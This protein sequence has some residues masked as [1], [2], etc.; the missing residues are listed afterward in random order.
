MNISDIIVDAPSWKWALAILITLGLTLIRYAAL[1]KWALGILRLSVLGTLCFLLLEPLLRISSTEVEPSTVVIV[2]DASASQHLGVD[3]IARGEALRGWAESSA[4]HFEELGFNVDVYDFGK[5]L[6]PRENWECNEQRT[7]IGSALEGVK[8]RYAHRNVS[9]VIVSTDGV[10]NRG[11]DP[12]F[13]TALLETPHFFIGTG[14]TTVIRDFEISGLLCNQVTYLH[15]EFPVEV[16]LYSNGY[17]G[18]EAVINVYV[19]GELVEKEVWAIEEEKEFKS[20]RFQLE[21][22]TKGVKK[23]RVV[24]RGIEGEV[25]VENNSATAYVEVLESKRK[26]FIV[27]AAPHPDVRALKSAIETNLHQEVD[28]ITAQELK[29][30]KKLGAYDVLILHNLPSNTYPTPEAV[31]RAIAEGGPILFVGGEVMDWGGLPVERTGVLVNMTTGRQNVQAKVNEGFS[32]F[33]IPDGIDR[34]LQYWPPLTRAMGESEATKSLNTIIHQKLDALETDWPLLAFNKDGSGRRS[35]VLM[36]EGIWRWRMEEYIKDGEFTT[37]DNLIN[38]SIQYLDSRDDVRRFRVVA[39]KMLEEDERIIFSAQVYDAALNPTNETDIHLTLENS[40]GEG[41]DFAFSTNGGTYN[42]DCGRMGPGEYRWTAQ[43]IL[44]NQVKVLS[45]MVIITELKAELISKAA[46]HGLLKR[47][48]KVTGGMFLGELGMVY[49]DKMGGVW[50]TTVSENVNKR[51]IIHEFT[52]R[53]ELINLK[54]IL[55]LILGGLTLE[56][57]VRRRQGGY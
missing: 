57:I 1:R 30:V 26:I 32:L 41:W 52:E 6:V 9:A 46:D 27:A 43:T 50:A 34:K 20:I 54:F 33:A 49:T 31:T 4:E 28:I 19:D 11:R 55:W 5:Q 40:E 2:H 22:K 35:G 16:R 18:E 39:P 12:E 25:R 51:D 42:L 7:D 29:G 45:G 53:L 44:D 23:V 3:S 47:I 48:S 13:G 21:A 56:W 10:S 38:N 37:F 36:G 14:D 24:A 15:N 17:A 8:N